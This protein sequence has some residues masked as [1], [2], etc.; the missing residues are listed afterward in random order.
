MISNSVGTS[1][2]GFRRRADTLYQTHQSVVRDLLAVHL[3]ALVEAVDKGGGVKADPVSRRMK[4]GRQHGRGA[5]LAIGARHMDEAELFVRVAQC[6]QQGAGCGSGPACGPPTGL[7]GCIH[8]AFEFMKKNATFVGSI[9]WGAA[10]RACGAGLDRCC[11]RAWFSLAG[12]RAGSAGQVLS[13]GQVACAPRGP[14][15]GR[16]VSTPPPLPLDSTLPAT[17]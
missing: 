12:S 10:L 15:A 17:S 8:S 14:E 3:N 6:R 9:F 11:S 16:G 5:A 4:A 7:R 13:F 1:R 2:H